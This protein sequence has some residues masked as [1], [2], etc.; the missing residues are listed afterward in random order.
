VQQ[1]YIFNAVN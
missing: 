1:K